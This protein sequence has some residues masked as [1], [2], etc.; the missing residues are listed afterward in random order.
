MRIIIIGCG[1]TGARLATDLSVEG[2]DVAIIDKNADAF[3]RL[4]AEFKGNVVIGMGFDEDILRKAGSE[5]ADFL[6]A[7]T[8]GDNSNIMAAE[9]AKS[10]L[11]VKR[12]IARIYDPQRAEAFQDMGIETFCSTVIMTD[13]VKDKILRKG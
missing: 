2:H 6:V 4:G 12:V 11:H 7:V 8:N 1:R 3:R 9:V 13:M 5:G 10:E